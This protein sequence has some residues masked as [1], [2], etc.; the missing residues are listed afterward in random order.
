MRYFKFYSNDGRN[1]ATTTTTQKQ[2]NNVTN[3]TTDGRERR[4]MREGLSSRL[5]IISSSLPRSIL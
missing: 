2:N 5:L 3:E 1:D 4:A